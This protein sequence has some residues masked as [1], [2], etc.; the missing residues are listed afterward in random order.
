MESKLKVHKDELLPS[1]LDKA[2]ELMELAPHIP[3]ETCRL[4][5][6]NYW[7]KVMEQSFDE[8]QHQ[9]IGQIMSEARPYHSFALFLETRKENE[10]FKKYNNGGINLKVSV[11]DLLTGEVGLAKLVRGELGWTIEELKQHIGEVFII[12]SSCMRIVMGEKD[13]Q[14]GTSVNDISDVGGTLR[15]ILI[16][17]RYKQ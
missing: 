5:E 14:G 2:Y 3:I 4:V 11:V 15:E 8:F 17:S 12:N 6:Y 1:V 13:R 7:R 9:T 16:I 10:T